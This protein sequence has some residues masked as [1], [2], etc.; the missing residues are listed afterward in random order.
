MSD[1][2][3]LNAECIAA[4]ELLKAGP[5]PRNGFCKIGYDVAALLIS[6]RLIETGHVTYSGAIATTRQRVYRITPAGIAALSP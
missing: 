1:N 5:V 2:E 3:P 4:L 6:R